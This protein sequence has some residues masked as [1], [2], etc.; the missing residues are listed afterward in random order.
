MHVAGCQGG[1]DESLLKV[2]FPRACNSSASTRKMPSRLPSRTHCWKRRWQVRFG[3]YFLGSSRHWAPVPNTHKIPLSTPRG[4]CQGRPR[5][6]ER[7]FGRKIGSITSHWA[8]VSSHRPRMPSFCLFF[9]TQKIAKWVQS[10]FMRPV[11]VYSPS[12]AGD[13]ERSRRMG[14]YFELSPD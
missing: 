9:Y 2:Q 7:R 11:L 12:L 1:L 4:S 13:P 10:P 14:S 6:S 3:G 5:P 8:S